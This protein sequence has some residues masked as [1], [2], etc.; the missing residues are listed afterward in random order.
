MVINVGS[1]VSAAVVIK[2]I[3]FWGMTSCSLLS[4]NRRFG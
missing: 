1:E 2:S 4:C 3:I